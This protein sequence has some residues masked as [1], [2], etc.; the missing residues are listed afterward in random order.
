MVNFML[1]E[2]FPQYK[3]YIISKYLHLTF[4][5]VPRGTKSPQMRTTGAESIML[6]GCWEWCRLKDLGGKCLICNLLSKKKYCKILTIGKT[7]RRVCGLFILPFCQHTID[8][9]VFKT[10]RKDFSFKI[11]VYSI[12]RDL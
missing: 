6:L 8:L 3:K 9:N 11:S 7:R 2:F 5:N 12:L 10:K 1:Y 4:S